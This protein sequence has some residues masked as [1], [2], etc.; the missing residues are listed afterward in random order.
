MTLEIGGH[1]RMNRA[2]QRGRM[3]EK[4]T[5]EYEPTRYKSHFYEYFMIV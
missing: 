4:A 1:R 2:L 5:V 3:N